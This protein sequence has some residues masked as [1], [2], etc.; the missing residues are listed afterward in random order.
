M[1][2]GARVGARKGTSQ[3][4][5]SLVDAFQQPD[6]RAKLLLTLAMLVIFRFIPV[7]S[8]H[9]IRELEERGQARAM[10]PVDATG[11]V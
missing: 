7:L 4:L 11:A 8:I 9:E 6:V 1:Q 2:A 5:T 10:A 3:L